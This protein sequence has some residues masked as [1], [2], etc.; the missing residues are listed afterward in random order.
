M[1]RHLAIHALALAVA[2]GALA[3]AGPAAAK[4]A[5]HATKAKTVKIVM[6]DPGCHW[7]ADGGKYYT[8]LSV[9]GKT[10]FRNVDEA[11]LIFKGAA[12]STKLPVGRSLTIAKPGIYHITMVGQAPD[13]NHLLLVVK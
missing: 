1:S 10:T 4:P 9:S 8:G 12:A 6:H 3:L 2:I 13:D 5:L 7:F 11:A